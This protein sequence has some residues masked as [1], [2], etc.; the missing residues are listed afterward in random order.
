MD[1]KQEK[2]TRKLDDLK[3]KIYSKTIKI[4]DKA[5]SVIH[6]KA[7]EVASSWKDEE[8]SPIKPKPKN[9]LKSSRF[10]KFFIGSILFFFVSVLFGLFMFFGESNTVSADNIDITI[11]GNAFASGG[12]ELPLQVQVTNRN[13]VALEATDLLIE[14]QKG[15]SLGEEVFR[16]RIGIGDISAGEIIKELVNVTLFGQQG[17]TRDINI[18]LEY[19]VPGS[20]AIFVKNKI[21]TVNISSAPVNLIVEG[22]ENIGSNQNISFSI[23]SGLNTADAVK[24]MIVVA[25]YP[26]G[27]DFKSAEPE[28][29]FGDNVWVLG[30]ITPGTEK[31]IK[32]NGVLVAQSG[33][34][35]A[36]NVYIGQQK[37][38]NE[39]EMGIQ[40]NSQSYV[41]N[42]QKPLLD[43]RIL[44]NDN[45]NPEVTISASSNVVAEIEW[46]NKT[47]KKLNDVEIVAEVVGPIVNYSSIRSNGFYESATNKI[48]WNRQNLAN[49]SEVRPGQKGVLSISFS[50]LPPTSGK[51]A[52]I[53]LSIKARNPDNLNEFLDVKNFDRKVLK[54]AT[55]LQLAGST[56]YYNGAFSNTGPLPPTPGQPTTYTVSWSLTN[57]LNDVSGAEVRGKLPIYVDY[58]GTFSPSGEN[59]TYNASTKEV[60]WNIG[61]VRKGT[62]EGSAPKELQFQVRL[63]PSSTQ[64]GKVVNLVENIT[65]KG[66]DVSTNSQI[67]GNGSVITTSLNKDLNYNFE[68][69]KVQ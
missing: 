12:E 15:A 31:E 8:G 26:R 49:F 61:T 13:N 11:L 1:K 14:Y 47:G 10:R 48:I 38:V 4:K 52:Y 68:N 18:T 66:L 36:F 56:F 33:E 20:N 27:F 42:I 57:S 55:R 59:V 58:V 53:N 41:V 17:T 6:E 2:I 22:P 43:T 62:G 40:F 30:D 45:P 29:T 54:I 69:D 60:V 28:P 67:T 63:N 16:N 21:Y 65:F 3:N 34:Q 37:D 39:R 64:S 19:R 9:L 46:E 44:V 24:D 32:V 35:R 5:R 25:E 23:K 50:T 51:E 7:H